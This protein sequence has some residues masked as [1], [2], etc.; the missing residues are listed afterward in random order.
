MRH[1]VPQQPPF[2]HAQS[3]TYPATVVERLARTVAGLS[4]A[5]VAVVGDQPGLAE[6][7]AARG[8]GLAPVDGGATLAVVRADASPAAEALAG[9]GT[10]RVFAWQ[11]GDLPMGGYVRDAAAA[12]YFRS[13]RRLPEVRSA[14]CVLLDAG[15][16]DINEIVSRYETILSGG[17]ELEKELQELRHQLLASRDRV[18][19]TEAELARIRSEQDELNDRIG[20]IYGTTTWRIGRALVAPLGRAKRA[21]RK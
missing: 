12:G 18:L 13:T 2:P 15:E 7:L 16:F 20:E 8:V 17:P 5:S 19:G 6:A 11:P 9:L 10:P 21:L 4:A 14:S 3:A 1:T